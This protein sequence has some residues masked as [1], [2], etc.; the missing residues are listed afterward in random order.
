MDDNPEAEALAVHAILKLDDKTRDELYLL[1]KA[2][3]ADMTSIPYE[4]LEA[5]EDYVPSTYE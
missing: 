2:I 5:D 1:S 4:C 3:V